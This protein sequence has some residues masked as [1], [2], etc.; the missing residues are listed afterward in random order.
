MVT[1]A[2]RFIMKYVKNTRLQDP[3]FFFKSSAQ[4]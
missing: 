4:N 1:F 3:S 2:F